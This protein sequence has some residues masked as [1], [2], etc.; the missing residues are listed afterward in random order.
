MIVKLR[1]IILWEE[2]MVKGILITC[3]LVFIL[4]LTALTQ[5]NIGHLNNYKPAEEPQS[6]LP[7]MGAANLIPA[8]A[9][10]KAECDY[11]DYSGGNA[12]YYFTVSGN[13]DLGFYDYYNM[14]FTTYLSAGFGYNAYCSLTTVWVGVYPPAF[15]GEP[16]LDIIIWDDDNFGYPYNE[17][18]R[19]TISFDELPTSIAYVGADISSFDL[20]YFTGE[21]FHI[22]VTTGNA[23]PDAAVALLA[24]D[25]AS[26]TG[27]HSF[28]AEE[29]IQYPTDHNFLIGVEWCYCEEIPDSDGDGVGNDIDN[30]RKDYNPDQTDSD[31]DG[32]G[33]ACDYL[34]GD[35]NGDSACNVGDV[36]YMVSYVFRGGPSP[37]P[38][39]AGDANGD[40]ALNIGDGVFTVNYVFK[41][42]Q[43]PCCPPYVSLIED[44]LWCKNFEKGISSDSIP[45]NQDC[46][47]WDYD[48]QSVLNI[49]HKNAGFNCCPLEQF[50]EL[51]DFSNNI[52][53]IEEDEILEGGDGCFCLCLFNI[54]YSVKRLPPGEYT[55]RIVGMYL[56]DNPPL[57]FMVNLTE[58]PSDGSFCVM[59]SHYPWW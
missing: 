9:Q 16:D 57:E 38:P 53:V 55:I 26:G 19:I 12:A 15:V 8:T 41:N 56:N 1:Y 44:L 23:T 27:R 58:S 48:G 40:G 22:G 7:D 4:C 29:W 10:T 14:R 25:G 46:L 20:T 47:F 33:E 39:E 45:A 28:W 43:S 35:A 21:E 52:I 34:C 3:Y 49:H 32:I 5:H 51:V 36:V 24:D 59:R 37:V 50:A 42:G 11:I 31:G 6:R 13:P 17:L 2:I 54:D 30:C 18:A